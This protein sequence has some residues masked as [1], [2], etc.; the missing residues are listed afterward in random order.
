MP[1][2]SED[3]ILNVTR[4]GTATPE[5]APEVSSKVEP[6]GFV[7]AVKAFYKVEDPVFNVVNKAG[8]YLSSDH[9]F[10]PT[11]NP[12]ERLE[13]ERPDLL[14]NVGNFVEVRNEEE[15]NTKVKQIDFEN[16]QRQIYANAPTLTKLGAGITASVADPLILI[17]YVGVARHAS[18]AARVGYGAAVGAGVGLGVSTTREGILSLTQETRTAEESM[19]NIIAETA[20][21]GLLGAGAGALSDPVKGASRRILAKALQ[22]EDFK[23]VVKGDK[24]EISPLSVGAAE[25]LSE[26]DKLG[27]TRINEKLAKTLS[28]PEF[29]RAPDLR[30]ITSPSETVRKVGEI[31]YNSNYIREKH[32]EGIPSAPNAQNAIFRREQVAQKT[33]K[34]I[35]DL[36]LDYTGKGALRSTFDF[37]RPADKIS[38]GE[39]SHRV[40]LNLVNENRTDKIAQV[41]KAAELIRKDMDD[42]VVELQKLELLPED[43][44]PKLAR[45]YMTRI[46]DLNKLASPG[47]RAKFVR[48]V[49][50]WVKT[51]HKSGKPRVNPLDDSQAEDIAHEILDNIRGESDQQIALSSVAEGFISKGKFLKER[52]LLIPD[53]E[54]SEFVNTD[55]LKLYKNYT[56]K[57]SKLIETQRALNNAGFESFQDVIKQIRTEADRAVRGLSDSAEDLAKAAKIGKKFKDEED[58]ANMMYRSMLGQ[59]RK[60]GKADRYAEALLNYQFTRLLGGVTISSL[61]ELIMVPFRKGFLKTFRDGYLPMIKDLKASKLTK[62][63]LNDLSGALEFE[64]AN[65][66]RALGGIDDIGNIG[67]NKN[68]FERL[69]EG[70]TQGFVKATGIGYYTSFGRRLASQVSSADIVRTLR[71]ASL[72]EKDVLRL[73][74]IGIGKEHYEPLRTQIKKH[75]Q[76]YKG[77]FVTNPQLW[78]DPDILRV[79]QNAIQQDVE[80]AILKPGVEA[81]PFFVQKSLWAKVIFQFKSFMSAATGK[82]T[83]SGLQRRDADTLLG[84]VALIGMGSLTSVIHDKIAGRDIPEDPVEI[85]LDG[86]S[87]SGV[88]GL[89]GTTVL[90]TSRAFYSER[91]RRFGGKFVSS[92]ILGPSAGQIEEL[93]RATQGLVDGDVNDREI[94]AGLRM[95]PFMNLFYIKLLTEQAFDE[96]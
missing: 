84:L 25:T 65:I 17:P 78:D 46:Y 10:D 37:S 89:L 2:Y 79:F 85:L 33:L 4:P 23:V 82:I 50:S 31:F 64:Q 39:Y 6:T 60:P 28:G 48:K 5:V 7:D 62:N 73:A 40:W 96:D 75:V 55:A 36:Y 63:Q 56:G 54:I 16:E 18:R 38:H 43:L 77:S 30:A 88:S 34:A 71:K 86:I 13:S 22:G 69:H 58:L 90:D 93:V 95:I 11:F 20:L 70:L 12:I 1:I 29:L 83:I 27:L 49:S 45:N 59:L 72:N 91:T 52:Q 67:R 53:S 80:S 94:K 92:N 19:I 24:A 66:L 44:N 15:Y 76:S 61:P 41:N 87:R 68:S 26:I 8:D 57:V 32:L 21:G 81:T 74:Q 14:D 47:A 42:L 3:Q 51:H 9:K 35:D